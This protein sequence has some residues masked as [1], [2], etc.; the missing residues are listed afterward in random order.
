MRIDK[1]ERILFRCVSLF[2]YRFARIKLCLVVCSY[3]FRVE[4]DPIPKKMYTWNVGK[5][6]NERRLFSHSKHTTDWS[7]SIMPRM[8]SWSFSKL[9]SK[10]TILLCSMYIVLNTPWLINSVEI[11]KRHSSLLENG[12]H[13][14][15]SDK[16]FQEFFY[17]FNFSHYVHL[18]I[19][20]FGFLGVNCQNLYTCWIV[21]FG[22]SAIWKWSILTEPKS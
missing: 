16:F 21:G 13:R 20:N 18:N 4:T 7:Q 5:M 17:R 10:T 9:L 19:N 14:F 1:V 11:W 6:C 3:E 12:F 15:G 22:T 8:Y 2:W